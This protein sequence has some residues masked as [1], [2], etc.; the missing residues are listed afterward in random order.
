MKDIISACG[1][2]CFSC[3][4]RIAYLAGDEAKKAEIATSWS[5]RYQTELSREDIKCDGC[6]EGK[7]HFNWC[8][9][10]PIRSC[11]V[12]KGY[13]SCAECPDFPCENNSWLYEQ[14][15]AAKAAIEKLR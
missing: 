11:V 10:C 3:E 13:Q 9:R 1:L 14:V 4:C 5:K 6:M 12:K 15:P 8:D 7:V 2:D